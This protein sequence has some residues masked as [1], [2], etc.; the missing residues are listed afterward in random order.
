ME[1]QRPH[2][3]QRAQSRV[4]GKGPEAGRRGPQPPRA[5]PARAGSSWLDAA[6]AAGVQV[7]GA[8]APRL[9]R[10]TVRAGAGPS[11]RRFWA[12]TAALSSTRSS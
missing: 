2:Q 6:R 4:R 10:C 3:S 1:S 11:S 9:S 8:A 12:R 7:A 5:S